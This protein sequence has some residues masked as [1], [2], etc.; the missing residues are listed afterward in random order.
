MKRNFNLYAL[1]IFS[2][3]FLS[4]N[5]FSQNSGIV[6]EKRNVIAEII[7]VTKADQRS[8]EIMEA[9]FEQMNANYPLIIKGMIE[10]QTGLS[11]AE[12]SKLTSELIE[13][14]NDFDQRFQQKLIQAINFQEFI[15]ATIYPLY[16]KHFSVAELNDLLAF[17]KTPTG[18]KLNELMPQFSAEAMRLTQEFLN[19]KIDG[20]FDEVIREQTQSP[21]APKKNN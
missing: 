7:S 8:K 17:Y 5:A 21:P 20:I 13:K 16:D 14:Q 15:E 6:P 10:K 3:L 4:S 18:Q 12:K 2:I 19:P 1:I 9:M 11:A